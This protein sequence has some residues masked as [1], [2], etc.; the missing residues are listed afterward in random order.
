MT[1]YEHW[2]P[3]FAEA[4]QDSPLFG[5]MYLDY[6]VLGC[7][8]ATVHT[9]PN[10]AIVT[11]FKYYPGAQGHEPTVKVIHGLIAAG[12]LDEIKRLIAFAEGWGRD[13]G[14]AFAMIESREGWTKVLKD[15]GWQPHQ[16]T[17]VKEL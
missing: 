12:D 6:L 16:V 13:Q 10:A 4:L 5:I 3:R 8:L 17:L 9:M 2:R 11:E 1:P 14:C 7:G 15:D